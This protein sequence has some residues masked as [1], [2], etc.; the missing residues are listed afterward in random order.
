M[1]SNAD[2][3]NSG[4]RLEDYFIYLNI[5][6]FCILDINPSYSSLNTIE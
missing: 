2:V 6:W 1:I 3:I 4:E 5:N